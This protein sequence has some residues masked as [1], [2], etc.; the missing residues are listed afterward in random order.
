MLSCDLKMDLILLLKPKLYHFQKIT[1]TKAAVRTKPRPHCTVKG[2]CTFMVLLKVHTNNLFINNSFHFSL[3]L[4][5][6]I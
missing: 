1:L 4:S 6:K 2:S 5:E 3:T